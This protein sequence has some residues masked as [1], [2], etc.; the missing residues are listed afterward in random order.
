MAY[1]ITIRYHRGPGTRLHRSQRHLIPDANS[2]CHL[3]RSNIHGTRAHT[4]HTCTLANPPLETAY[5]EQEGEEKV[6]WNRAKGQHL[7]RHPG[8]PGTEDR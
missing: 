2:P 8:L 7:E 5:L 4:H 1:S 6:F 3:L